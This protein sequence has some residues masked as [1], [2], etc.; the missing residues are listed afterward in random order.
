MSFRTLLVAVLLFLCGISQSVYG[1][2]VSLKTNALGWATLSPNLG[3]ELRLSR[4]NTLN[5]EGSFNPFK[6]GDHSLRH[7]MFSPEVRHWFSGRPQT[8]HFCGVMA[9]GGAYNVMLKD[10]IHHG[11][12]LG[13]GGTYG[14]SFVLGQRW[15][16][17]LT[18]GVGFLHRSEKT[19]PHTSPSSEDRNRHINGFYPLKLGVNFVYILK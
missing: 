6:F 13:I 3:L 11:M 5:L 15:S 12:A 2:R 9:V 7:V 17:E 19:R 16:M 14:Y 4:H 8:R 10:D 1:Q 18:A